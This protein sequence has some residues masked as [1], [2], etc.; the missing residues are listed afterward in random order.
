MTARARGAID[1]AEYRRRAHAATRRQ[2][3]NCRACRPPGP[4]PVFLFASR[5]PH[6]AQPVRRTR[7]HV[8]IPRIPEHASLAI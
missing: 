1:R 2:T 8:L 4:G 7:S 3:C 6:A 5:S